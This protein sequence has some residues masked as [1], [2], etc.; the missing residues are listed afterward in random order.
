MPR[1]SGSRVYSD[2]YVQEAGTVDISI[3]QP[4]CRDHGPLFST[5]IFILC[6]LLPSGLRPGVSDVNLYSR[7]ERER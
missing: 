6:I 4:K 7:L 1:L 5:D 2:E 3:M